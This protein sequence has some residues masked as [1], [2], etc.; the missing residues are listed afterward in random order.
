M[1]HHGASQ[2]V[3]IILIMS[4]MWYWPNVFLVHIFFVPWFLDWGAGGVVNPEERG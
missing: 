1:T 4:I 2:Y 3:T